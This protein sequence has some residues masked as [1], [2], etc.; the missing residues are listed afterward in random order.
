MQQQF[1]IKQ[2]SVLPSLRMQLINDGKSDMSK[3][4]EA[5]QNAEI[6][7]SMVNINSGVYKIANGVAYPKRREIDGCKDEYVICYDWKPRDT[8]EKGI[9][10]GVFTITF[11]K[12]LTSEDASYPQG[13]LVMPINEKLIINII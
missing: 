1:Y 11:S 7:F 2:N 9:Y 10:E 8:K 3:F 6:T 4:H 12:D 13:E 5:I